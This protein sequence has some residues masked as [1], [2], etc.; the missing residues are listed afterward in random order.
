M[1]IRYIE[2]LVHAWTRTK[3][4]LFRP[5]NPA[6]W[7]A[8]GFTAFLAGLTELGQHSGLN[9]NDAKGVNWDDVVTAPN[10]AWEWFSDNPAWMMVAAGIL[11]LFFIFLI[12]A[13]WVSSRGKFMFLDNVLND[14]DL[15][16][17][18]WG[19][20]RAE[21]NSLF[22]WTIIFTF[23]V[24]AIVVAY[25]VSAYSSLY[26]LYDQYGAVSPLLFS[27]LWMIL[28]FGVIVG[29]AK[30]IDLLVTDFVVPI[31]YK[32]RLTT[33]KAWGVFLPLLSGH[34]PA[35]GGYA[36]LLLLLYLGIAVFVV[37]G[38]CLTCC[39]GFVL[40]AIPYVGTVILLPVLYT[41]RAFSIEFLEQFGPEYRFFPPPREE[42]RGKDG[43]DVPAGG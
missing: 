36:L 18:P 7:I 26:A 9:W 11:V 10:R 34:L 1:P 6:K 22:L 12:V 25:L 43:T 38:G 3:I 4:A 42:P 16:K 17:H 31:M 23:L 14:R 21:G 32:F 29:L 28:G 35:F 5:L 39:I 13:V 8:V 41:L 20:Y 30:L 24:I 27:A 37:V 2:P 15:V 40:L 33:L 19:E